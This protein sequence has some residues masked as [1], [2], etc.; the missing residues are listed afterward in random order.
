MKYNLKKTSIIMHYR[1]D[2]PDREFN[3]KNIYKFFDTFFDYQE[4][5]IINDNVK[6][7]SVMHDFKNLSPKVIG[8]FYENDQPF[9]KGDC[10]NKAAE[11]SKGDILCFY[12]VDILIEPKFLE[13]AQYELLNNDFDHIYPHNGEFVT[14]KK[15]AFNKILPSFD[16][17]FMISNK[18]S[19][20][21]EWAA[22]NSPGGC[23]LITKKSFNKINGYDHRFV[24]WG[25]E[26]TDFRQRSSKKNRIK[27]LDDENA[28]CWHLQHDDA[29]K[30]ENPYFK[31]NENIYIQNLNNH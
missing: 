18:N 4:L 22:S 28:I 27:Y 12:D 30:S 16:F 13:I 20:L 21:F 26:D 15:E 1:E 7:D 24:G 14:V 6:M 8:L 25:Y 31:Y 19:D 9:R 11:I 5:I 2:S 23:N 29:I 10:F 17:D 3:L